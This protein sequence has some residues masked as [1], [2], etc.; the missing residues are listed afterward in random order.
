MLIATRFQDC[1]EHSDRGALLAEVLVLHDQ[2]YDD[3]LNYVH[4]AAQLR[5][6]SDTICLCYAKLLKTLDVEESYIEHYFLTKRENEVCG[7]YIAV[8]VSFGTSAQC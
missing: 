4:A 7:A 6:N 1:Y 8:E 3:F 2:V 5:K